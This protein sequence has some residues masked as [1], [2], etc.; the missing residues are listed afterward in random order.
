MGSLSSEGLMLQCPSCLIKMSVF[1]Q[2][3]QKVSYRA[4]RIS[5]LV[6]KSFM[7]L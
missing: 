7:M 1:S 6:L 3:I 2:K 5:N 4:G